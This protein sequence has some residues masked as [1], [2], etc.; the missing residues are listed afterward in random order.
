MATFMPKKV[1]FCLLG[2][3]GIQ[4]PFTGRVLM[5]TSEPELIFVYVLVIKKH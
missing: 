4:E 3:V 2:E 1:F 5:Q